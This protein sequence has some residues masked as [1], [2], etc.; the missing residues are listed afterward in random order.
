MDND[1]REIRR[2]KN[3]YLPDTLIQLIYMDDKQA[4]PPG[5]KGRV[6]FVDDIGNIHVKWQNGSSL[7]LIDGIDEFKVV[8]YSNEYNNDEKDENYI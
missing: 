8:E 1:F 7:A 4:P 6:L 3:M 5:T 2:L